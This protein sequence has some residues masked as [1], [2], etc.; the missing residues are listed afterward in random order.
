MKHIIIGA[1]AAGLEAAKTIRKQSATDE[2][3]VLSADK[4][5]H[6]R[7]MLHKYIDGERSVES[8]CF[9]EPDFFEKN[10]IAWIKGKTVTSIDTVNKVVN[11]DEDSVSYDKLLVATGANS[12]VPPIGDLR[13]A[14]NV[15][16]LRHLADAETIRKQAKT[17]QNVVVIG[18]GLVGLD[19]AYALVNL[20]KQVTVVEMA[21]QILPLN[22]DTVAAETYQNLFEQNG[23][24]FYLGAKV[25]GT[26]IGGNNQI[27]MVVLESGEKL[28]CDMIIVAAGVRPAAELLQ[29]SGVVVERAV[30]VD[31]HMKTSAD[32]VYAA[33]DITGL[34]EIW[35]SAVRQGEVAARNMCG[36]V[37]EFTDCFA[38]KNTIN[39][40][41][42]TTLSVG[43][44]RQKDGGQAHVRED[45]KN[46][47]KIVTD[48]GFI[49][50]VLLQGNI[51]NSGIWQ[52]LVK[53]KV[54]IEN[55][56]KP[57]WNL[58]F[59]DFY[60]VDNNGGYAWKAQ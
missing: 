58:T 37:A 7:C 17:A 5:V 15:F 26:E 34:G 36:E 43:D 48:N 8:L 35:P 14:S 21:E 2:I 49:T 18:A 33:G 29:G 54:A 50:G 22:L 20:K 3:V 31:S 12:A 32:D 23:C 25:S 45:R 28:P 9:V 13:S 42:L 30:K 52:Y 39:F 40:F 41:G 16:G 38:M 57:V 59:A 46:Y 53:N 24:R 11:M 19:A 55:C 4:E 27:N 44:T 6:S 1:G 10:N 51:A 56:K 47:Q 60:D